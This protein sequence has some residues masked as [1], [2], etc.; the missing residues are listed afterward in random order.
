MILYFFMAIISAYL[1]YLANNKT[2]NKKLKNMLIILS[3]LPFFGI[4]AFRYGIGYDY[5]NIYDKIFKVIVNGGKGNWEPGIMLLIKIIGLFSKD[6]FYFFF[7]SAL[8]TSVF[9]YKGILKNSDKP[10]LS[11]LL[12]I[13]C[14]LYMDAMNAVRQYIAIAIFSYALSFIL[15]KD[16]KRYFIWVVIASLFHSSVLIMLP[17]YFFCKTKLSLKK[18]IFVFS[19]LILI[20][21]FI[22]QIFLN[23][24][25]KTKYSFYLNSEYSSADPTYSELIISSILFLVSSLLY[26]NNK[27]DEKFNIYYNLTFLFFAVGIMSFKVLLAYRIIM[28]FKISIIFMVPTI[29]KNIKDKKVKTMVYIMFICLFSGITLIGA[30]KLGWYDTKYIS[31]FEKWRI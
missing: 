24:I 9:I 15:K 29:I 16:F 23:L 22:N 4:L 11:L 12:F 31:I 30:Y 2:K 21:P 25:A 28:Y 27:N 8:F 26:K 18:K 10:S 13:I 5:L 14:G 7:I 19:A 3:F 6:S 20:M 17:V 1:M